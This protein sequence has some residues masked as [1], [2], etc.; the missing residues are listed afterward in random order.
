[1]KRFFYHYHKGKKLMSIHFDKKC[2]QVKDVICLVPCETKWNNRQ[3]YLVM[4]GFANSVTIKDNVA[5]IN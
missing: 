3:P 1:M 5:Y 2:T 4:R